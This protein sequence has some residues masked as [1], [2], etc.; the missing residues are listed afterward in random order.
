[1]PLLQ[2]RCCLAT[3]TLQAETPSALD[4]ILAVANTVHQVR[5]DGDL[6]ERRS[7]CNHH[8]SSRDLHISKGSMLATTLDF[9]D[10]E[11]DAVNVT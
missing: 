8:D 4:R 11:K 3:G 10:D 6:V 5:G 2:W 9:L 7:G 1:M